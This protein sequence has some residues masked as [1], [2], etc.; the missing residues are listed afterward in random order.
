MKL[1][2]STLK[3]LL[4]SLNEYNPVVN[5]LMEKI[6][7]GLV[8]VAMMILGVLM[9]LELADT[10]RRVQVEQGRVNSDILISVAWKYFVGFILIAYSN[11]I[12]DSILWVT[13][14]IGNIISKIGTNKSNLDLVVPEIKG[15]VSFAQKM[16]LNGL[17]AMAHFFSWLA[18]IVT[19]ILVFLRVVELFIFKAAAPVMVALYASEEWRPV[20]MRFIKMFTAVAIQGFLILIILKIYPALM[21]NDM[22]DLVAKG[23]WMQNLSALFLSLLKSILFILVLVGSQRKAKEWMGG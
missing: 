8:P 15:K 11:Q 7:K 22:F 14:A 20:T 12:F 5:Q 6:S 1:D 16:I 10:N 21:S 3:Q 9:Y 19:K 17:N 23:N 18:E 2:D 4:S 13:N